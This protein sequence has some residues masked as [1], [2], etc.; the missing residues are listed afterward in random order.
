MTYRVKTYIAGEWEGDKE[1]I[2][3]INS[4]REN[5]HLLLRYAS[6]HDI[7]NA[8]DTSLNCSIKRS[9]R[10]RLEASKTFLLVVGAHTTTVTAGSCKH[11]SYYS[12][13]LGVCSKG[14]SADMKSYIEY[15]CNY[16]ATHARD[17]KIIVI[18]NYAAVD[19]SKCP[20]HV[21]YLGTHVPAYYWFQGEKHWNYSAI[22]E[23]LQK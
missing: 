6:A 5:K 13:Y 7:C 16:A 22:L 11:C 19:K 3:K 21:R 8:R 18:Y 4:W 9:L 2:D 1:L 10:E 23:A 15:E 17:M 12:G 14:Y 20:E